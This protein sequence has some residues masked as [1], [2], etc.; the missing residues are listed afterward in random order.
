[1]ILDVV[2]AFLTAGC[3]SVATAA[4]ASPGMVPKAISIGC[5]FVGSG[6][7]AVLKLRGRQP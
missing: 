5:V 2:M 7:A 1:M 4:L 3:A 6:A